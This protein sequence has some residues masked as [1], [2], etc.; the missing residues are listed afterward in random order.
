[1]D[2]NAGHIKQVLEFYNPGHE[3]FGH[4]KKLVGY[5]EKVEY[6]DKI[7]QEQL[8]KALRPVWTF[9]ARSEPPSDMEEE[10]TSHRIHMTFSHVVG[11]KSLVN[12]SV[13]A[14][15]EK[16]DDWNSNETADQAIDAE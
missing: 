5:N 15:E 13:Y 16:K 10:L 12:I 1:M 9:L 11:G 6:S 4:I 8:A 3:I 2:L 14:S 7:D